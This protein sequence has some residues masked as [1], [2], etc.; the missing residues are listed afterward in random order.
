MGPSME[1]AQKPGVSHSPDNFDFAGKDGRHRGLFPIPM[2]GA[3]VAR[4]D[5]GRC[6]R[7]VTR[8][9]LCRHHRDQWV[10]DIVWTVNT[11]FC[12]DESQGNFVG[13]GG[14]TLCQRLC[15]EKVKDAVIRA[16]KPPSITGPEALSELRTKPGYGGEPSSLVALDLDL[17]S[18]PPA[19]SRAASLNQ[20]LGHEAESFIKVLE[21]KVSSE[22]VVRSRK[23]ASNLKKPYFDPILREQPRKYSQFCLKL[24]NSGLIEFHKHVHEVVGAFCVRKKNNRQRLVIDSRLANLHFDAPE[25]VRLCTGSTFARIEVGDSGGPLEV[26]G[27]DISDAFYNI[28]LPSSLRK[29]FGLKSIRAG[30]VGVS[31]TCDGPVN[32]NDMIYPVLK[33]VPMGWTHAL[34][35]CQRCHEMIVDGIP[36]I[37][38]GPRIVDRQPV[39]GVEPFVHTE[40]VDNFVALSQ[41][42][43]LV[44]ELATAAGKELQ[45]RGLPTHDVEAGVGLDTLGWNFDEHSPK[46]RVTNKRMWRLRLATLEL[47]KRDRADGRLIEKLVGHFTFAGL[48][49]RGLLSVFQASYAFIRKQYHQEVQL[50]AEVRRELFLAASL[51]CMVEKDLSSVWSPRVHATDASFWGRGVVSIDKEIG[52]VK[53]IGQHCDRWRFSIKEEAYARVDD[54]HR[55]VQALDV[56]T[57]TLPRGPSNP[58]E[59]GCTASARGVSS[60]G[61]PDPPVSPLVGELGGAKKSAAFRSTSFPEVPI[62]FLEGKWTQVDGSAWQRVESIPVLEGRAIVWLAQHL[63]RSSKNHNK[64]HLVLTD[65]MTACLALEKGR[66]STPSI[67]RICRQIA[68][69]QFMTGFEI[70][71]RWIP[72]ELNPGDPPSRAR[73]LKE[74]DLHQGLRSLVVDVAQNKQRETAS[75]RFAAARWHQDKQKGHEGK[76]QSGQREPSMSEEETL[77]RTNSSSWS[78]SGFD[79][80]GSKDFLRAE[81]CDNIQTA[82]L[83]QSVGRIHDMDFTLRNKDTDSRTAGSCLVRED[84]SH[85]FRRSRPS[86]C[87]DIVSSRP[88]HARR[89]SQ[90]KCVSEKQ[91]GPE[92]VL[93]TRPSSRTTASSIPYPLPDS[94]EVVENSLSGGNVAFVDVGNLCTT[95]GSSPCA[96]SGCGS[97]NSPVQVQCSGAQ[98]RSWGPQQRSQS[99]KVNSPNI[100]SRRVR[101]SSLAGSTVPGGTRRETSSLGSKSK[102]SVPAVQV[103]HGAGNKAFQQVSS[104]SLTEP[105][106]PKLCLPDSSWVSVNRCTNPTQKPG[107]SSEKGSLGNSQKCQKIFQRRSNQ[108]SV[109]RTFQSAES[110]SLGSR[111]VDVQD[112][113]SWKNMPDH[114]DCP[115]GLEIFSGS[116]HMSRAIRRRCKRWIVFEVDICHGNMFDL[117]K[118]RLQQQLLTFIKNNN[119]QFVWLGTPCNSWSRARRNDGRGPGPLRDDSYYLYGLPFLS[120]RDLDKVKLGNCLMRFSARVFRLCLNLQIPIILENPHTSRLWLAPPI[121]HLLQ[122][123]KVDACYTDYCQEGTPWRK[124]T[125]LMFAH[126]NLRPCLRQCQG[127]R[128]ICSYSQSAHTTL[129][130]QDS[131]G[132][133]MT[134]NAQP[135]P[136]GLCRRI[137]S[138]LF[139]TSLSKQGA[140]LWKFFQGRLPD[141]NLEQSMPA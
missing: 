10:R 98:L 18:L 27:V 65:S 80:A 128:G 95:G 4:V 109:P 24:W 62:E 1:G 81:K 54:F 48:L 19:G 82:E 100:K 74:F 118:R 101:R 22:S 120:P 67:N 76:H 122:H 94:P 130:G 9:L 47:L 63:A 2:P 38:Q 61:T 58:I 117:S 7:A 49:Q 124:R 15:L 34:W 132:Q 125:R 121:R 136:H 107:G 123:G 44:F 11:M 141:T 25:S 138:V 72:S 71:T 99:D 43:G 37:V 5:G 31:V 55:T 140:A 126:V 12:G 46:V 104:R 114:K 40:Y 36:Q 23:A 57:L 88:V 85:V 41:R 119:V 139:Q 52:D 103:Q 14:T 70:R 79:S 93:Q 113:R 87:H 3:S 133:W 8:R 102:A 135:Y 20:I 86:R 111:K 30:D 33:V 96:S 91:S 66:S 51:I 77:R 6:S 137:A 110:S 83:C 129:S 115:I 131:K 28:G 29:F 59:S 17:I 105:A 69:L 75:W 84:Q 60:L 97:S 21:S 45:S 89:C 39:P 64:R 35:V 53:A 106:R 32:P 26:G 92:G 13:N 56:E 90:G 127:V 73:D 16:G 68:A 42:P 116:G 112:F 134:L 50:W 78:I 108:S